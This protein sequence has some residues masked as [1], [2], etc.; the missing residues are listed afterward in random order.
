[1]NR[2]LTL[3]SATLMA[4]A[5]TASAAATPQTRPTDDERVRIVARVRIATDQRTEQRRRERD[6]DQDRELETERISRTLKLGSDG[7]LDVSNISGDVVVTRGGGSDTTIEAIK[8][9]RARTTEE[10]RQQLALVQVEISERGGRGELRTR[11]PEWREPFRRGDREHRLNVSVDYRITAPA[12]LRLTVKSISGDIQVNDIKGELSLESVSGNVT[13]GSAGRIATA[14]SVSGDVEIT[15]SETDG[16]LSASSVSGDLTLR[17]VKARRMDLGSVS[18]SLILDGIQCDRA[19]AQSMSGDVEFS[20]ALAKSGRYDLQSHSGS[21][22]VAVPDG[23]GFDVEATSFSGDVRSDLALKLHGGP[24]ADDRRGR[25][26]S[27]R[28]VYGDGGA[29]LELTTFSGDIVISKR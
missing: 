18:G 10:A 19:S 28:G 9:A 25:R 3:S 16:A 15:A 21:I 24:D 22:R 17:K 1:M 7:I 5:F 20:G 8:T 26:R 23:S 29:I 27:L 6:R 13:I 4:L 14:K 2:L 11:Y 12:G